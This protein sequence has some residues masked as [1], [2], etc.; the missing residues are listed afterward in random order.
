MMEAPNPTDEQRRLDSIRRTGLLDTPPESAFDELVALAAEACDAPVALLGLLDAEREWFKAV[1]GIAVAE[2]PRE[3]ALGSRAVAENRLV[4][5]RDAAAD[6]QLAR[7][8]L[9]AS[10]AGLRFLAA[11]PVRSHD[12]CVLGALCVADRIPRTLSERQRGALARIARLASG[13]IEARRTIAALRGELAQRERERHA[14]AESEADFRLLAQ[15]LPHMVWVCRS[16]GTLDYL[17]PQGLEFFGQRLSDLRPRFR[18]GDILHPEDR[19]RACSAWREALATGQPLSVEARLVAADGSSRWHLHRA[20]PVLDADDGIVKWIG[21]S[22]DVH[23]V[24]QAN[25]RNAFLLALSAEVAR[26]SNPQELVCTAM[27]RLRERLHADRVTLAEIDEGQDEAILLLQTA[28]EETRIEITSLGLAP[29]HDLAAESRQGLT[30]VLCDTR[31]DSRSAHLYDQWYGP[32]RVRA[33][34]SAPLLRGGKLVALL[35]VIDSKPREWTRSE[36]ELVKRV[37]DIVWPALEKARADRELAVS[38]ERLRLTQAVAQIGTWE[39]DPDTRTAVYSPESC[40]LFG[41]EQGTPASWDEWLERIDAQDR[42]EVEAAMQACAERGSLELEYRYWHPTRGLRW[43]YCKAG[44][45]SYAGQR[46]M[47]GISL[48]VTERRQAEE[49]LKE[50]NQRKDE[51]LAMLAHELRN[52]LAPI[53]NAAQILR[54]HAAGKPELEWARAVIDRQTRHL[55]R[56]VDDLLDVSRIVRGQIVLQKAPIELR[57]IVRHAVETSRPL[58]RARRHRFKVALPAG[59]VRLEGDLTRLAQVVANLLNNAAKYTEEGGQIWL[60]ARVEGGMVVISV[61][62]TGFGIPPALL[63]RIFDLFTQ[64]ERTLDRSQGG[65]GIGLTL[66]RRLVEMHGGTVEARSEGVGK[67]SEFIVRLPL[68]PLPELV[69][70]S[71]LEL[72]APPSGTGQER[73]LRILV[74]D[75]NVDAAESIAMLLSM[76]GH[77]T[78]SVHSARAALEAVP[79]FLPD[80]VLLDIGLPEM[81]GY[82]VARRLRSQHSNAIERM[83]LVA[84]TGYGQP[85][86]RER[87]KEAGFDRHLVKPVEPDALNE[88]LRSLRDGA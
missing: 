10:A 57:D 12:G 7:H 19:E 28:G 47:V 53:R 9:V 63:P 78:Q 84:V 15:T 64:A 49:A 24:K 60:D 67:G 13:Q 27:E 43:I 58:I 1:R 41:F 38:E 79:S 81:D 8:P 65:L 74:V 70:G 66:V 72:Q 29:F 68:L 39:W 44:M 85:E 31:T 5:V 32:N 6:P 34:V 76:Q 54:V 35:S 37:A 55:V 17:N 51:F 86:D 56:L 25:E 82:E 87:A 59:S 30:T 23:D 71:R 2:L 3:H 42:G 88:F 22:T 21:T 73:G 36:V 4:V 61:R 20:Q 80:V 62:D 26:I 40:A 77:E 69:D 14:I 50:I 16:D 52:P 33:I 11:A 48:D 18:S 83:R 46:R 75:D 45:V